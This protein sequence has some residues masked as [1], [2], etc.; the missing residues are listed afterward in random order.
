V[1]EDLSFT[2]KEQVSQQTAQQVLGEVIDEKGMKEA[3]KSLDA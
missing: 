1:L 3:G 2:V